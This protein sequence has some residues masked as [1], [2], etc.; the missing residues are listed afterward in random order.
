MIEQKSSESFKKLVIDFRALTAKVQKDNQNKKKNLVTNLV[1]EACKK[2]FQKLHLEHKNLKKIYEQQQ[3][4]LLK[5]GNHHKGQTRNNAPAPQD[6]KIKLSN[7]E[8]DKEKLRNLLAAQIKPKKRRSCDV[9]SDN[10]VEFGDEF[11]T[12]SDEGIVKKKKKAQTRKRTVVK[13]TIEHSTE[14]KKKKK[15]QQKGIIDYINS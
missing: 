9:Y 5:F 13:T 6:R 4:E 11:S 2:E 15:K 14:K 3:E 10:G 12:S 7:I 1:L 8:V